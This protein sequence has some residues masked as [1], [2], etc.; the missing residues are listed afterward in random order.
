MFFDTRR[1][2]ADFFSEVLQRNN[3]HHV[4]YS[5]ATNPNIGHHNFMDRLFSSGNINSDFLK[6]NLVLPI[7]QSELNKN[8]KITQ[9]NQNFGY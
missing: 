8:D 1:R 4:T 9:A 6:K 3:N 2:G 7:P 5:F